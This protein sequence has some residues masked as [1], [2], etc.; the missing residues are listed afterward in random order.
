MTAKETSGDGVAYARKEDYE[1]EGQSYKADILDGDKVTIKD[2]GIIV[3]GQY[4]PQKK[5]LVSTRNGDKRMTLNQS[6]ENILIGAYGKESKDWIGKEVIV[7][8]RKAVIANKKVIV[9]YLVTEGWSLDDYGDL[10]NESQDMPHG[11]DPEQ[12]VDYKK[13]RENAIK[14][15]EEDTHN[16]DEIAF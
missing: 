16:P 8:T 4:G 1:W 5:F 2:E 3:D 9:A 6:S 15:Q 10:V 7:L 11:L 13:A 14:K 12:Q